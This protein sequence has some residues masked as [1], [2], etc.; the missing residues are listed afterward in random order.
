[1]NDANGASA[2]GANASNS[3]PGATPNG[4]AA[5]NNTSAPSLATRPAANAPSTPANTAGGKPLDAKHMQLKLDSD[6]LAK[7]AAELQ[8]MLTKMKSN[9]LSL[10]VMRKSEDVQRLA[11]QVQ[12][13]MKELK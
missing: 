4:A 5:N 6:A 11:K 9:T 12:K 3:A 10:A 2:A 1:V 8:D 7:A 13:D